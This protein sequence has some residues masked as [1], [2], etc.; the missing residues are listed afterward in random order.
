M[1][2]LIGIFATKVGAFIQRFLTEVIASVVTTACVAAA[3]TLYIHTMAADARPAP[4]AT[5]DLAPL[6]SPVV[7]PGAPAF[8]IA[9]K[10]PAARPEP[11]AMPPARAKPV[12]QIGL[13]AQPSE[14]RPAAEATAVAAVSKEAQEPVKDV[15]A[16]PVIVADAPKVFDVGSDE[17]ASIE[18]AP[19]DAL[20]QPEL[21]RGA[22]EGAV[23]ASFQSQHAEEQRRLLGLPVPDALPSNDDV[24]AGVRGF[25]A[26]VGRLLP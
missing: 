18:P 3:T 8:V 4:A 24:V 15:F 5:A 7:E 25:G 10:A 1:A 9:A 26:A 21:P 20:L 2:H 23:P 14:R 11:V 12:R 17:V 6:L 19:A 22:T 16:M 13:E